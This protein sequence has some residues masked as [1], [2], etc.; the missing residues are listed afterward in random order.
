MSHQRHVNLSS[1]QAKK[2]NEELDQYIHRIDELRI[3]AII[4]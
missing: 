3:D 4:E 2:V 1:I